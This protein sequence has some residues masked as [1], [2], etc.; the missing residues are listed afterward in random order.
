[1]FYN[2]SS[3]T[4]LNLS[5]IDTSNVNNMEYMFSGCKALSSLDLSNFNTE[6]VEKMN[7]MFYDCQNLTLINL[8]SFN[9]Q[10]VSDLS[11]M[12]MYCN[13]LISLNLSN[14]ETPKL[15][16]MIKMFESCESLISLDI[17][18]LNT[19]LV[20]NMTCIFCNC[21]KLT[22]LNISNFVTSEVITM[23]EMFINCFSLT[24]LD[25]SN[26][27][28]SKVSDFRYMFWNCFS[29]KYLN[30][31]NF[32][33]ESG[34]NMEGMFSNCESLT[35]LNLYNFNTSQ[36]ENMKFMFYECKNLKELD[37]SNFDFTSINDVM[38]NILY[39]VPENIL[40]CLNKD[41]NISQI[42]GKVSE[43][44]C[45]N[46]YCGNDWKSHQK[47]IIAENNTCVD[48]C[49]EY[50]YEINNKCYEKMT[51][52]EQNE[53]IYQRIIN[54][55]LLEFSKSEDEELLIEGKGGF[56]FII[57][58]FENNL[59][60]L[61]EKNNKSIKFS[62]IYI[63]QKCE[64]EIKE[65]YKLAKNT[66]LIVLVYEK[67]SNISSKRNTQ[68]EIYE[69]INFTRLNI[70][71][72]KDL[73]I[74]IY[75][76]L[77]LSQE[78]KNLYEELK[79]LGYDLFDIN[80]PFYQDICT[81][82]KSSNGTDVLLADRI[83]YYY[84]N[85]ETK[86]Q[87][88]CEFS[89]YLMETEYLKCLCDISNSEI[90]TDDSKKFNPKTIYKSFYEVLK[91]S[92]YKVLKCYKLVFLIDSLTN[93]KGSFIA[94]IFVCIYLIFFIL[95]LILGSKA[96]TSNLMK[97]K[98]QQN[99][100]EKKIEIFKLNNINNRNNKDKSKKDISITENNNKK[101]KTKLDSKFNINLQDKTFNYP[102]KKIGIKR[103]KAK[104][105]V[106]I[107]SDKNLLFN[108]DSQVR[109]FKV[110]DN[111]DKEQIFKPEKVEKLDNFELNNLEYDEAIKLDKRKFFEIYWS[112]LKR[113]HL[114]LFTFCNPNDYNI[115]YIKFAGFIFLIC[116]D[117]ALNVFF[118]ADETMH[119]MFLDYGKFDFIQQIPQIIYSTIVSQAIQLLI[120][121]LS[122]TD[123][124]FYEI[125]RID[126][127]KGNI[128]K[129]VIR[130]IKLKIAYFFLFTFF[131]F[132]FYWYTISCFCCVYKNT[133]I[134]FIKD[135]ISSFCLG[136]LYPFILY[137][138]P[139]I[140]RTISL[141]F[142]KKR[143]L[144]VYKVSDVIPLF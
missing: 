13:S 84:N 133:Q 22:S 56:N 68:Y 32:N 93:N 36:I 58:N 105:Q 60:F 49:S 63:G 47:K 1:M 65:Y 73:L 79:E 2:C 86:C 26:F 85:N 82:Y 44:Y 115:I 21:Q 77:E 8:S 103:K 37:L 18:N 51:E 80:A 136:L 92:N 78:L 45:Q 41:N 140:L 7:S 104:N 114:I 130:C 125:K 25:L 94:L 120:N 17:S 129:K 40:I 131:M 9:T 70:S 64:N 71:V 29:L 19:T 97:I 59:D 96:L 109:K 99:L 11:Y 95:Y 137:L 101:I 39:L 102:P 98:N 132:V 110:E 34:V 16:S 113:E 35:S 12:F 144:W 90:H 89:D 52:E 135:S 112:L 111:K 118:F 20:S 4:S 122:L 91:F 57:S 143:L 76:P 27:D 53:R 30:I 72:C 42:M 138:F 31:S 3:L 14:F 50:K 24:S 127:N 142:H 139:T 28:T 141:K 66:S 33:T 119:K 87:S 6:K 5:N 48:N 126:I 128:E 116:T 117:M 100:E 23:A 75:F 38:D 15:I 134:A 88:N 10:S 62:K 121:F 43:K 123:K 74:D 107:L 67:I 61:E 55:T 106:K 54:S 46:I 83:N 124:Y 108:F 69:S 81:P